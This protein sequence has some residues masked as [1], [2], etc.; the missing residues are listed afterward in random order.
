GALLT[1]CDELT[2]QLPQPEF[3]SRAIQLLPVGFPVYPKAFSSESLTELI[4]TQLAD[5]TLRSALDEVAGDICINN[6]LGGDLC[7]DTVLGNAIYNQF[8]NAVAEIAVVEEWVEDE[9]AGSLRIYD[10]QPLSVGVNEKLGKTIASVLDFTGVELTVCVRNRTDEVWGVPIRFSLFMGDSQ[11]VVE[12]S[13]L[14]RAV[15]SPDDQNHTFVLMPGETQEI[16]LDAPTLVSALN[17]VKSL[18]VDYDAVVEV[19]D[20]NANT[21]QGWVTADRNDADG[22]GV[23]DSLATWGLVFEEL[24]IKVSGRGNIDVPDNFPQWMQDLAL[25]GGE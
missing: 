5:V 19:A 1:S 23:A 10:S 16:T 8:D 25:P 14:I 20:L 3:S 2:S 15:D 4:S 24:S 13:A 11:S 21:F 12:R 18:A 17:N 7:L 9:L 6:P 22:N